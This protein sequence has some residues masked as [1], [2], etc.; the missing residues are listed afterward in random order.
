MAIAALNSAAT[1]L[2]ALSTRID[3]IANNLANAETTA[4]KRSRV[5]FEDLYYS[6]LRQPGVAA[7]NGDLSPAGIFVGAGVK[8]SNTQ[9]DVEQGPAES[10][11]R[12]LDIAIQGPGWFR[13]RTLDSI[14]D[15]FAYT[16]NGNLFINQDGNLILGLGDGYRLQPP[17]TVP[18]GIT[19]KDI[20]I[21][22]EGIV[23]AIL[24]GTTTR[25]NLGQIQLTNFVNP[26]GLE[27]LGGSLYR[28]TEA[29]G[30]PTTGNPGQN[31]TGVLLQGFL[32]GSNVDP[33]KELVTLIKTQRAFELNSQSIQTADQALQ[34]IANLRRF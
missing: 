25:T 4:F 15:G 11:G 13:V 29:S 1:G 20:A 8:V 34:T 9:L 5:N 26:Q 22:Q 3:V 28:E 14:G 31:G 24:P 12:A 30:T 19:E 10:T 21:S 32:E 33:V 7:G 17:I 23:S 18:R 6:V 2:R 16:R 27:L